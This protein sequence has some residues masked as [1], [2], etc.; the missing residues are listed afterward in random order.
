[1]RPA[2]YG[3]HSSLDAYIENRAKFPVEELARHAGNWVAFS[4]DGSRVLDSCESLAEL[5]RLLKQ[6]GTDIENVVFERIP[7]DDMVPSGAA[8]SDLQSAAPVIAEGNS[9]K[10]YRGIRTPAG[11]LVTV[12]EG[13]GICRHL[14]LRLDLRQHSPTGFEWSHFSHG[15]AQLAL[16]LLADALGDDAKAQ[17]YY[18]DFT[19]KV[20]GRL[21]HDRWQLSQEDILRNVAA[22]EAQRGRAPE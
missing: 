3:P 8:L 9:M 20:V 13:E 11:C 2:S 4:P 12:R 7:T 19:L 18:Q 14:D 22:L 21:S 10:E 17:R 16:A 6:A 1:M 5:D 15:S